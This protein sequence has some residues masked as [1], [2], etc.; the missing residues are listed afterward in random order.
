MNLLFSSNF[1]DNKLPV[2]ECIPGYYYDLDDH[3]LGCE[4]CPHGTYREYLG[5]GPCTQCPPGTT[6]VLPASPDDC[7]KLPLSF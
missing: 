5:G 4:P 3:Y 6:T 2:S 7:G 1:S